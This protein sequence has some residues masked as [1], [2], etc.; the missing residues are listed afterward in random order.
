[1]ELVASWRPRTNEGPLVPRRRP[2]RRK[3]QPISDVS[4]TPSSAGSA[5]LPWR[6]RGRISAAELLASDVSTPA[7][8][9]PWLDSEP[10]TP[11]FDDGPG[12]GPQGMV[13]A[14]GEEGGGRMG[15]ERGGNGVRDGGRERR[16]L[17]YELQPNRLITLQQS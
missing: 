8:S 16:C 15:D 4:M 11:V 6:R 10:A 1:M 17:E 7:K 3:Q 12:E 2:S 14:K 13:I 5:A 9:E